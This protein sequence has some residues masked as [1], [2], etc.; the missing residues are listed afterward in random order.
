MKNIITLLLAFFIS[1]M[2]FAQVGIGTDN[3][4]SNSVLELQSTNRALLLPRVAN[5]AAIPTPVNGM[6]IYD[7][8]ASC[9]KS[10]ENNAWSSCWS[11][12]S[13]TNPNT[14]TVTVDCNNSGFQGTML[15][16]I[17]ITNGFYRVTIV[18]NTFASVTIP[19]AAADLVL[20]GN[21][22]GSPAVTVGIIS[23]TAGGAS[24][25]SIAIPALAT[26][27][28]FYKI[29]G[30]PT[31]SGTLNGV[32]SKGIF[33]CQGS[34]V[35]G[36]PLATL[37]C[38]GAVH[39]GIL[40]R[41]TPA[42][43]VSS[44]IPYT[45]GDG[46]AHP[47]QVVT[48]TGVTGL[49]ATLAPGNFAVG[50]GNLNYV[51]TGTPSA[52]GV[53]TF[54]I[55]IGGRT[56][57]LTRNVLLQLGTIT[58]LNCAGAT[59]NGTLTPGVVA[60]GVTSVIPYTGGNSGSHDGQVVTSTGVT[61]LTA[62]LTAGTFTA[63]TGTLT[64]TITGT[65][66]GVGTAT[67]AINIGG[68]SCNLTRTVAAITIPATITLSQN[69]IHFIASINDTDYLPYV[70]ATTPAT[71]DTNVT[72]DGV[73]EATAINIQGTLTTAG[74]TV[75]IPVTATGTGTLP[76]FFTS[77][78]IPSQFT[79]DGIARDVTLSWASQ[80]YT[81]TTKFITATIA[82]V[83]GTLNA[84][85][86]DI[87]A[88]I[89]NDVLGVLMGSLTYPYNNAGATTTYQIRDIAGIPD[90]NFGVTSTQGAGAGTSGQYHNFLYIPTVAEDGNV[91]LNNNLGANYSNVNSP[92]FNPGQ[93]A[94]SA[95]DH[96]AYG[97]LYQWG[98]LTDGH[99]L[100]TWT[101]ATTGVGFNGRTNITSL[102]DIP[103]NRLFIASLTTPND[104]RSTRNANLWQGVAGTNNPCPQGFRLPTTTELTAVYSAA[105]IIASSTA[106]TT[107]TLINNSKLKF[108][109][110]GLRNNTD[111]TIQLPNTQGRYY[112]STTDA[113]SS[114][115]SQITP[116]SSSFL[117]SVRSHGSSVRCIID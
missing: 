113:S 92:D 89:G 69:R 70:A 110:A 26:Q 107:A 29:N 34:T 91:W 14:A 2:T 37:N 20:S 45:G 84:K 80:A 86:L 42:S 30:N 66:S 74:I 105:G 61:G 4:N 77:I 57:N 36:A 94:T 62:T 27:T 87:N 5:T 108:T 1:A 35:I 116:T 7:L 54:A 8:S 15:S 25:T 81:A 28:L 53:A 48:S 103:T 88:G 76:A 17:A 60:S 6:V 109:F 46:N 65:P 99:E 75:Q 100:V 52:T 85:K 21:T 50:N 102:T 40:Y 112:T 43:D 106:P 39:N 83:G 104:W 93:Q 33:S 49:T 47:G 41:I 12:S 68:Q 67:F 10:F 19:L 101:N 55:S 31:T 44:D 96:K 115:Y 72:A 97:S 111:N 23:A 24:I 117:N 38:A 32:W 11:S 114:N 51:I 71:T 18:N 9:S 56:C 16:G 90:R 13:G 22:A 95:S 64:Y 59:N 3:P 98:R 73:A 78:N 63:S 58:S 79:E 82:A